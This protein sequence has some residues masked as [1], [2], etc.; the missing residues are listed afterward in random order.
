MSWKAGGSWLLTLHFF[1][2]WQE[3]FLA[4]EFFFVMASASLKDGMMQEKWNDSFFNFCDYFQLFVCLFHC[5]AEISEV[6]FWAP[7]E[8]FLFVDS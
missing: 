3:Y 8:L 1:S 6:D 2:Q 7:P 4:G 5:V